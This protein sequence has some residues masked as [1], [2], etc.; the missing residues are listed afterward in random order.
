M[1]SIIITSKTQGV[2]GNVKLQKTPRV[3]TI[4]VSQLDEG[5]A[6]DGTFNIVK[7]GFVY[8]E[9]YYLEAKNFIYGIPEN[10]EIKW[11]C[12]Y[13]DDDNEFKNLTSWKP[14]GKKVKFE[15]D[16]LNIL[17]R[18]LIFHAYVQDKNNEGELKIWVHYR[19]R[20][21]DKKEVEKNI[22]ARIEKPYLVNQQNTSLCAIATIAYIFAKKDK[23]GYKAFITDMHQKGVVVIAQTKYNIII[24]N[25][26]HL[27]KCKPQYNRVG[28]LAFAD[29]LFLATVRDFKNKIW[30]YDTR[31][32]DGE[33]TKFIEGS[34]GISL[35][36]IVCSLMKDIL[37]FHDIINT[38]S[39][40]KIKKGNVDSDILELKNKLDEGYSICMLIHAERLIDNKKVIALIPNHW[41]CVESIE[42]KENRVLINMFT[43]GEQ[44]THTPSIDNFE[45]GY[46]GYIA[47]K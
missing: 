19:F 5:S 44:I 46:F 9:T 26:E 20:Y 17:G 27:V 3:K 28:S 14:T 8:G 34:V 45:A 11:I 15:V 21:L 16:D 24:D 40:V 12:Q 47:G 35:P 1:G 37:N 43:W 31:N 4:E 6:N 7:K 23:E 32:G 13:L 2:K 33:I 39:K 22:N 29:Y 41:I 25:D 36:D 30:D 10:N 18:T 38:T 42:R